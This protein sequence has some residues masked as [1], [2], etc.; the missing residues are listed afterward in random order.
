MITGF[1]GSA[2]SAVLCR[3]KPLGLIAFAAARAGS[4]GTELENLPNYL[5][6]LL[7]P[8]LY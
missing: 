6:L 8:L 7:L 1:S 4:S 3:V 2:R 5:P